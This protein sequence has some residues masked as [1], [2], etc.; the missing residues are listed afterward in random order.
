[1]NSLVQR[2]AGSRTALRFSHTVRQLAKLIQKLYAVT[3]PPDLFEGLSSRTR[4]LPLS[5]GRLV[6]PTAKT[7]NTAKMIRD[8]MVQAMKNSSNGGEMVAPSG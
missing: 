2:I 8:V 1:L 5:F 4:E 3:G 7:P 6:N